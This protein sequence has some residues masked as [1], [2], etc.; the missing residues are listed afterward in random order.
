MKLL[1]VVKGAVKMKTIKSFKNDTSLSI[2]HNGNYIAYCIDQSGNYREVKIYKNMKF[3]HSHFG[4]GYLANTR[5]AGKSKRG[6]VCN[7]N[8]TLYFVY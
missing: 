3:V 8:Q 4:D 2:N 1:V 7:N 6:I 5:I